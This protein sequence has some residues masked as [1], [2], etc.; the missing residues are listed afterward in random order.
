MWLWLEVDDTGREHDEAPLRKRGLSVH[1]MGGKSQDKRRKKRIRILI[2]A[3]TEDF[4]VLCPHEEER[5]RIVQECF[6]YDEA[7]VRKAINAKN[8]FQHW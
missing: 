8:D 1:E 6:G 7:D 2:L 3:R 5:W 4:F